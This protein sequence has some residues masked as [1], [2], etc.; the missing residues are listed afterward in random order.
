MP[1]TKTR[2]ALAAGGYG[3][4]AA[5][6]SYLAGRHTKGARRARFLT[7]PLLM[8]ALA[9]AFASA[10]E[11]RTDVLR[12]GTLAAQALSWGGDLAL[13]GKNERAFLTGVGSFA[14]AHAAY[15]GGFASATRRPVRL[16]GQGLKAAAGMWLTTAPVMALAAGRKSPALRGP[17]AGYAT[18]LASMFASSTL[19]GRDMSPAARRSIVA[20]TSLFLLSDTL[21]ATQEFLLKEKRPQLETAVMAT[22]TAG[23]ALIA[24]GAAAAARG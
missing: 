14:G 8:P 6:D 19:V 23:Q 12:R 4:L 16:D 7:K 11:G 17:V 1:S 15:I 3:A 5:T 21:L 24:A 10:T 18:L 22:Y 9:T 20:G 2:A 13:L